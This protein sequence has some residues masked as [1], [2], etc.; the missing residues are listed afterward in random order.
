MQ[1]KNLGLLTLGPLGSKIHLV[2]TKL[3]MGLHSST[4]LADGC[5]SCLNFALDIEPI[6][7]EKI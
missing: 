6:R 5:K 4:I 7:E 1:S 2:E 3:Q